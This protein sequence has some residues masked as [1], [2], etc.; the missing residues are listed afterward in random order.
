VDLASVIGRRSMAFHV[1]ERF[2]SYPLRTFS[3]LHCPACP[4]A[5]LRFADRVTPAHARL[6]SLGGSS[7]PGQDLFGQDLC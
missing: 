4:L 6:G 3:R 7:F 2:G 5:C 1:Y